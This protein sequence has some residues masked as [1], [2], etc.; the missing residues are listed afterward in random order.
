MG[1]YYSTDFAGGGGAN[2]QTT[3]SWT[4]LGANDATRNGSVTI[5]GSGERT[6]GDG[7]APGSVDYS[8]QLV[9]TNLGS[10]SA[11]CLVR[12]VDGSNFYYGYRDSN[13]AN[14]VIDQNN[15]GSITNVSTAFES[16][17][18]APITLKLAV[19]T[20]QGLTLY[21]GGV[22]KTSGTGTR[23][24]TSGN[25]GLRGTDG[26]GVLIDDYLAEDNASVDTFP[27]VPRPLTSIPTLVTM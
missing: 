23:S 18:T 7:H 6:Y 11:G 4:R 12:A 19:N 3:E 21:A 9:L 16:G 27:P 15:A 5:P 25:G 13:N 24:G 10:S 1:T 8:I 26:G 14:W 22:S 17:I 2:L 20:G